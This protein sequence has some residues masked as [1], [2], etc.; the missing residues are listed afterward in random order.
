MEHG[1]I[2]AEVE[3]KRIVVTMEGSSLRAAYS[4]DKTERR[5]VQSKAMGADHEVP[6]EQRRDFEQV[7]WEFACTKARHLG[8]I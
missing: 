5:L 1:K 4:L 2:T 3:G 8:W 7:A 6:K